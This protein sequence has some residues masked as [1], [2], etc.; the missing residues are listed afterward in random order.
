MEPT[1]DE[2]LLRACVTVRAQAQAPAAGIA[3]GVLDAAF[4]AGALDLPHV[5]GLGRPYAC[6]VFERQAPSSSTDSDSDDEGEMLIAA[7]RGREGARAVARAARVRDVSAAFERARLTLVA[8]DS[9]DCARSSLAEFLGREDPL[10]GAGTRAIREDAR[11]D[12][13]ETIDPLTAVSVD[14]ACEGAA[15]ALAPDLVV[16]VGLALAHFRLVGHG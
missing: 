15:V 6:V 2:P 1:A 9:A 8:V 14:P 4:A 16:P 10:A 12:V 5:V 3:P 11:E 13:E 7:V